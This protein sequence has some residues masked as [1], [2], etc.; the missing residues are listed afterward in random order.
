[1]VAQSVGMTEIK[2]CCCSLQGGLPQ[3]SGSFALCDLRQPSGLPDRVHTARQAH[4]LGGVQVQTGCGVELT[5]FKV[6]SVLQW[7]AAY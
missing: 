5:Y 6:Q 7:D 2:R 1:M 3:L 4:Q